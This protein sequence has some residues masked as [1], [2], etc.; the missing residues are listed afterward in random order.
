M[1]VAVRVV[2]VVARVDG[3]MGGRGAADGATN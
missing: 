3:W 1:E 2:A